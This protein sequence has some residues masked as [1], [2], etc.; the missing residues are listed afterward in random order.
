MENNDINIVVENI[1]KTPNE[2]RNCE[3]LSTIERI[4]HMTIKKERKYIPPRRTE[5][6]KLQTYRELND[7]NIKSFE[8]NKYNN[9][10]NRRNI[11]SIYN[12]GTLHYR[13]EYDLL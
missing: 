6:K 12:R 2:D 10:I 4:S 9:G 1:H 11:K 3:L 8:R 13:S 5:S 7:N